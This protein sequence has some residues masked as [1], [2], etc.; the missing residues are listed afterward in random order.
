MIAVCAPLG[1]VAHKRQSGRQRKVKTMTN[2]RITAYRVSKKRK[3]QIPNML[4]TYLDGLDASMDGRGFG[5]EHEIAARY[6]IDAVRYATV[7]RDAL[8]RIANWPVTGNSWDSEDIARALDDVIALAR[9]AF[10]V[11]GS[12][13]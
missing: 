10:D 3:S 8:Q 12:E 1:N 6:V 9:A 4:D 7:R 13:S 11:D 5:R 2:L